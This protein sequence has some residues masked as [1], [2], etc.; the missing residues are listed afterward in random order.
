MLCHPRASAGGGAQHSRGGMRCSRLMTSEHQVQGAPVL[1]LKGATY[2]ATRETRLYW[3]GAS[4]HAR[5][6]LRCLAARGR[7][8]LAACSSRRSLL[9]LTH[10]ATQL[11]STDNARHRRCASV[12]RLWHGVFPA[13]AFAHEARG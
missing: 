8:R 11:G 7:R 2:R 9:L 3:H 12:T 10:S 6:H 1:V 13:I 4:A 5:S